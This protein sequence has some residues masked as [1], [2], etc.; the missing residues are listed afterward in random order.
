VTYKL[1]AKQFREVQRIVRIIFAG[2]N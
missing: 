2:H 1:D